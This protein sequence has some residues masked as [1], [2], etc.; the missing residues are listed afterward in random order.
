MVFPETIATGDRVLRAFTRRHWVTLCA[1]CQSG[2]TGV[3]TYVA[4]KMLENETVKNVYVLSAI[5]DIALRDQTKIR[6]AGI[7]TV[8]FLG[9]LIN[10]R[11]T[12]GTLDLV[13]KFCRSL[14]IIDES[15]IGANFDSVLSDILK[16]MGIGANG[17]FD[18]TFYSRH[19]PYILSVSA[20][21]Y[22]ECAADSVQFKK[23]VHHEP[24][25]AYCGLDRLRLLEIDED[26]PVPQLKEALLT[27]LG[28]R[29]YA[30]LRAGAEREDSALAYIRETVNEVAAENMGRMRVV[31]AD[32]S[33]DVNLDLLLLNAPM[34]F[35][36]ILVKNYCKAGQT[37]TKKHISFVWETF[38]EADA[39][40]QGL[41]GRC[42][43][44][45]T[46]DKYGNIIDGTGEHIDVYCY[47]SKLDLHARWI[48]EHFSREKI[49][50]SG[51]NVK[52]DRRMCT[53]TLANPHDQEFFLFDTLEEVQAHIQE[54]QQRTD[55]RS[56]YACYRSVPSFGVRAC[57]A[58]NGETWS[59]EKAKNEQGFVR[60]YIPAHEELQVLSVDYLTSYLRSEYPCWNAKKVGDGPYYAAQNARV[61][62][63]DLNDP[64][65]RVFVLYYYYGIPIKHKT[66]LDEV[67]AVTTDKSMYVHGYSPIVISDMMTTVRIHPNEDP[68][69][70]IE[71][72]H[73]ILT[74]D[75]SVLFFPKKST[76]TDGE[77]VREK[78][79]ELDIGKRVNDD[80]QWHCHVGD[81]IPEAIREPLMQ[82]ARERRKKEEEQAVSM[83]K[84][85]NQLDAAIKIVSA[86][87][88]TRA[89]AQT[90]AHIEETSIAKTLWTYKTRL[91]SFLSTSKAENAGIKRY[92]N[93]Y[94]FYFMSE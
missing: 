25:E 36:V 87:C 46:R 70:I 52:P 81:G 84:P 62:Y 63:R 85:V 16:K 12:H 7:G 79:I 60:Q 29:T 89:Q 1:P 53:R 91:S 65:S 71:R 80:L 15:H 18:R 21:P 74:G 64:T 41:P 14:I 93:R 2:K 58:S 28:T 48:E 83:G 92:K 75:K 54:R 57:K 51:H 26:D 31:H 94:N 8:H 13:K 86:V 27:Y 33:S 59:M 43:G 20:T 69:R 40:A 56:R 66:Q 35:T 49:P 9:D 39:Q 67:E 34:M 55:D 44:Y 42:C 72:Y 73:S 11:K 23:I 76:Y 19:A 5:P 32:M 61:A 17:E 50:A 68:D 90:G 37:L 3:Y 45:P 78:R 10:I 77:C 24:G 38:K 30:I 22:A 6:L 82:F 4:K 47:K 88:P